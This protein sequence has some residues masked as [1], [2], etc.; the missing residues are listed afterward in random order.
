MKATLEIP[1]TLYR[2]VKAKSALEG[3]HIRL[4][5]IDLF[6]TW[7]SAIPRG[8]SKKDVPPARKNESLPPWF[9][10]VRPYALKVKSHDMKAV[11][12]SMA[13]ERVTS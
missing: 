11:R 13:Q 12:K 5:A 3:R 1:D 2:Q 8:E 7:V 6:S 4:V 10:A 9:G